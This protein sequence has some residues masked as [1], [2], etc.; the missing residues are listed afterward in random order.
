[1]PAT[2]RISLSW[3]YSQTVSRFRIYRSATPNGTFNSVGTSTT[4]SW[5]EV[6]PGAR[7]FYRVTAEQD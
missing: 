5:S 2:K 4:T 1:M 3:S 7:Y 6:V